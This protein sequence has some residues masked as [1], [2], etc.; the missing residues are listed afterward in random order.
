MATKRKRRAWVELGSGILICTCGHRTD[1]PPVQ[2]L[3]ML[4][5][6]PIQM[7]GRCGKEWWVPPSVDC[8]EVTE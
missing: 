8:D 4:A 3:E 5:A 2:P 7:C 6:R 1:V